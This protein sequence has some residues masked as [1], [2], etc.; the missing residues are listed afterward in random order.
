MTG[1]TAK[2]SLLVNE[3]GQLVTWYVDD[4][5][6]TGTIS[7]DT[8]GA[9]GFDESETP[10]PFYGYINAIKAAW[11]TEFNENVNG[12]GGLFSVT[13]P[14][15]SAHTATTYEFNLR[16]EEPVVSPDINNYSE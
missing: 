4:Q 16:G 9:F 14:A 12:G 3:A 6:D 15:N 1:G 11:G 10:S 8:G 7:K 13:M 5:S 2:G